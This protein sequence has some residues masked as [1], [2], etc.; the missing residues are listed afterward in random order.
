MSRYFARLVQRAAGVESKAHAA[1]PPSSS[2]SSSS[3]PAGSDTHDPFEAVAPL[4]PASASPRA[5]SPQ[6][7]RPESTA[8][9][10]P[11]APQD[12]STPALAPPA[13]QPV[14]LP[15]R[16]ETAVNPPVQP[17]LVPRV[18]PA[19]PSRETQPA[20]KAEPAEVVEHTRVERETVREIVREAS[21]KPLKPVLVPAPPSR[22]TPTPERPPAPVK[23]ALVQQPVAAL[24][25]RVTPEARTALQKETP[26]MTPDPRPAPAPAPRQEPRLVIGRMQVE[27][28]ASAPPVQA[29]PRV[30]H[31]RPAAPRASSTSP[32]QL[33][34]GLGQ[35]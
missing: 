15:V 14:K 17:Q 30:I 28:V 5:A 23:P 29:P 32:S 27:V 9:N 3:R 16:A 10:T 13:P 33:H 18:E 31:R 4:E 22:I 34:F 25:E 20:E 26:R 8:R 19:A 35:M 21:D 2:S 24:S 11:Q 6:A 12:L 7:E 1:P